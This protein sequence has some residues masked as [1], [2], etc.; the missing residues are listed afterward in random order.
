VIPGSIEV[1]QVDAVIVE[2]RLVA[3]QIEIKFGH[4]CPPT[5][6]RIRRIAAGDRPK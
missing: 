6:I 5:G 1:L 4:D 2:D 3:D